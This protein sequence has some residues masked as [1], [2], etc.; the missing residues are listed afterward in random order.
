M[1][2]VTSILSTTLR[3]LEKYWWILVL[4][5]VGATYLLIMTLARG[6]NVW[7]DEGYS[8]ILAKESVSRL[9]ALTAV[10]AHPPL[11]YLLLKGWG[12]IFGWSEFALRSLSA[13]FASLTVG[14]VVILIRQLFTKRVALLSVPF[15][16]V[17]PFFL[18]YGY[19]IRMYALAGLIGVLATI[20]LVKASQANKRKWWALYAVLVALGM[21]TLYMTVVIW[22]AH[23]VWL[24]A[25][26][27]KQKKP[28]LKQPW[29]KAYSGAVIL[30]V[31]YFPIFLHQITHSAL[32]GIGN[33][34][35]IDG[36]GGVL[37]LM[38]SYLPSWQIS[39]VL[40]VL[41][42]GIVGLGIYL[43]RYI[44]KKMPKSSRQ[45]FWLLLVCFLF[46]LGFYIAVSL[47]PK[48]F[49]IP[50][51]LAHVV[52]FFYALLGVITGLGWR[53][54]KRVQAG[55]FGVMGVYQLSATGNFNFER[56]QM[57]DTSLI[58]S[59]VRCDST[60]AVV[61]DDPYTYIDSAYYF[62]GC[63]LRFY[64]KDNVDFEGGY[65][66]LHDSYL[67]VASPASIDAKNLYVLH[68][69]GTG[70]F[71]PTQNYVLK[72]SSTFD[73]QVVDHYELRT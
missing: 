35:T 6:Q 33:A 31:P 8:I 4:V 9:L 2:K 61:A 65:A 51:Y 73:K 57:P 53:Y 37:G 20:V 69:V 15:L 27:Y 25:L 29:V 64:S 12:G 67:R 44:L 62:D 40:S 47:L 68:W 13:I 17:A 24:A 36:L 52:I 58:R 16:V 5:A 30:F 54:G 49:F 45:W 42:L 56:L 66:P 32:P 10:D 63:S 11:Y 43:S 60:T 72:S 1:I 34:L 21:Y 19:E 48:P 38:M 3:L 18:R 23:L 59:V 28:L 50:R 41:L 14:A 55:V 22:L 26:S 7:F 70:S 71:I 39:G 46:P